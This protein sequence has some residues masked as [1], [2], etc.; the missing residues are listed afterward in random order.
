MPLTLDSLCSELLALKNLDPEMGRIMELYMP[1]DVALIDPERPVKA[2]GPRTA[3]NTMISLN[4]IASVLKSGGRV[5]DM[6]DGENTVLR[7]EMHAGAPEIVV[8]ADGGSDAILFKSSGV[9]IAYELDKLGYNAAVLR[10]GNEGQNGVIAGCI[11]RLKNRP[12]HAVI[13]FGAGGLA[14]Y[15]WAFGKMGFM[16]YGLPAPGAVIC[17]SAHFPDVDIQNMSHADLHDF[18]P[19]YI[20]HGELDEIADFQKAKLMARGLAESGVKC[21]FRAVADAGANFGKG[22]NTQADGWIEEAVIFW[23]ENK[24]R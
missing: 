22:F 11:E 13:G 7:F 20:I 5:L 2:L 1:A 21:R 8:I 12:D 16:E 14:A 23:R 17:A 15:S 10:C 18:P 4:L 3:Y 9:P 24:N 19:V 6:L